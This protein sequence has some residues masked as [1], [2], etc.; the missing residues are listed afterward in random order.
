MGRAY[1]ER[2]NIAVDGVT[3]GERTWTEFLPSGSRCRDETAVTRVDRLDSAI[4]AAV[5]PTDHATDHAPDH[6]PHHSGVVDLLGVLALGELA[7][8]EQL[9]ADAAMAPTLADRAA[10][11]GMAVREYRHFEL[12]RDRLDE[13]GSSVD[14]A[15][16]AFEA[17]I[18]AFHEATSPHGWLEGLMKAYV[19]DGIAADFYR[20]VSVVVDDRT[21]EVMLEAMSDGG[22]GDFVVERVRSA[23]ESDPAVRGRLALW[24]RR[25]VG[26]ALVQAQRVATDRPALADLLVGGAMD[27]GADL[28]DWGQLLADLTS[29]HAA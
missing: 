17:P 9:T 21:R 25:L 7:G 15:T 11:A 19:G 22:A 16:T 8:F 14:E 26:E 28:A 6:E 23:I 12:I 29:R 4:V 2:A 10:L 27:H 18:E 5:N 20:A 24:G 1:R 3:R 13:L